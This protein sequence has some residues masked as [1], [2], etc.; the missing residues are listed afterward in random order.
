[1]PEVPAEGLRFEEVDPSSADLPPV[2]HRPPS[3]DGRRPGVY[4]IVIVLVI[5]VAVGSVY[6]VSITFHRGAASSTTHVLVP[7]G[8]AYSI[9]AGQYDAVAFIVD[10]NATVKG[11]MY[12]AFGMTLYQMTPAQYEHLV[13]TLN[14]SAGYEWTSG[15]IGNNTV[16]Q[17][18]LTVPAGQWELVW[19]NPNDPSTFITTLIGFYSD[20]ILEPS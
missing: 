3:T 16:Y 17:L 9:P 12:T 8:T 14:F 10:G 2:E 1:M 15:P 19:A 5:A 7:N 18:N 11:T 20:L 6:L 13:N 4:L